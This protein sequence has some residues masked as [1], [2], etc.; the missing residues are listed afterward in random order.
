MRS[1]NRDPRLGKGIEERE[2]TCGRSCGRRSPQQFFELLKGGAVSAAACGVRAGQPGWRVPGSS[3][4][5]KGNST[6]VDHR[7][8]LAYGRPRLVAC[9]PHRIA[10]VASARYDSALGPGG[11]ESIP[12]LERFAKPVEPSRAGESRL[13]LVCASEGVCDGHPRQKSRGGVV[14]RR[15]DTASATCRQTSVRVRDR[16]TD[17]PVTLGYSEQGI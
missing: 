17:V 7:L 2:R 14:G 16:G 5:P 9:G 13:L 10:R 1:G 15:G 11:P 4:S 8:T 6:L 12:L 3:Y